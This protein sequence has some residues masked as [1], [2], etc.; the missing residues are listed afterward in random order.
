M[1]SSLPNTG[2]RKFLKIAGAGVLA[3]AALGVGY[4]SQVPA[5]QDTIAREQQVET[6]VTSLQSQLQHLGQGGYLYAFGKNA[7]G[8]VDLRNN[9]P[10][11]SAATNFVIDNIGTHAKPDALGRIWG[12]HNEPGQPYASRTKQSWILSIDPLGM[13]VLQQFPVGGHLNAAEPTP[14]GKFV[15]EAASGKNLA[16]VI[17]TQT[18][19]ITQT[20][21]TGNW[22]CDIH[23]PLDGKFAYIPNRNDDTITE[24]D[25]STF[26]VSRTISL[27]KGSGPSM[28][29]VSPDGK[30]IFV[31]NSGKYSD[32]IASTTSEGPPNETIVDRAS[33]NVVKQ[34]LYP[35]NGSPGVDN[36]TPDGRYTFVTLYGTTGGLAVIDVNSLSLLK[37]IQTPGAP[38]G[39]QM[40][41]DGKYA[42][43]GTPDGVVVVDVSTLSVDHV[44]KLPGGS[45]QI[46]K[47]AK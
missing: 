25:T 9:Q 46:V 11:L 16:N 27:P 36:F 23:T 6:Q 30:Y 17:D 21:Q 20:V 41:S 18:L 37:V 47:V 35:N 40:G 38:S 22:P 3:A 2:R 28:L 29:T 42:Y 13:T 1:S 31:E 34:I 45:P 12:I 43:A 39:I 10:I 8:A 7:V 19:Q 5:L 26:T 44:V 32:Q 33:G 15:I 24:I 4:A 14:D